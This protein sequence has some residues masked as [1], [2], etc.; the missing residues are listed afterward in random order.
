MSEPA[1]TNPGNAESL[2]EGEVK[3]TIWEH[4][5][6][7]RSRVIRA[8]LAVL[9]T[10]IVAWV[11]HERILQ[12][13]EYPYEVAWRAHQL[14]GPPDL[15]NI[16]TGGAFAGYLQLS[17]RAG[18]VAAAPIVFYQ[19]WSFISPGL[20]S[21]EKRLIVPFVLFSSTLFLSGVAFG[22]YLALIFTATHHDANTT[23]LVVLR[24]FRLTRVL[25][26]LKVSAAASAMS[27]V[28]ST[29][30]NSKQ[31]L[32]MLVS[33]ISVV[34]LLAAFPG[35]RWLNVLGSGELRSASVGIPAGAA[36]LA[37]FALSAAL[38]S[39]AVIG[40]GMIGFV[41]LIA[42]HMVRLALN[43]SDHRVIAP[44][45]ALAGGTLLCLADLIGRSIAEPR[46]LPVG[47]VMALI[48][49]PVFIVLLRRQTR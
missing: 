10:T 3:M 36:R 49:A 46:E 2:P 1:A 14:P 25:R 31:G 43:T 12:W 22:Y 6:A 23:A 29:L 48:G 16:A 47:A 9:V 33:L 37:V 34:T 15:T 44:A 5:G 26:V 20:Y 35:G 28:L 27:L 24:I 45:A 17:L 18:I 4:L 21:K 8:G 41:G 42:P 19:L 13:L 40:G 39:T 30:V 11:Y 38:T 7:L 32:A